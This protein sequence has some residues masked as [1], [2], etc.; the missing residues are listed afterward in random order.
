MSSKQSYNTK[1]RKYILE[2]LESKSDTMVSVPDIV[3]YLKS[4]GENIN[5]TTVYRYLNKL[6]E[7]KRVLKFSEG[8]GQ[9]AVYQITGHKNTCDGHL[10][11]QCTNCG[12]LIHLNCEYMY[13]LKNHLFNDHGITIKFENSI[14][15]GICRECSQKTE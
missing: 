1:A 14:L 7:E 15:Y 11:I 2:Y 8:D 5:P 4:A 12:K 6:N 13:D 10:H 9:K 3:N